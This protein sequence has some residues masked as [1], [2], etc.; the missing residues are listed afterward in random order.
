M[1]RAAAVGESSPGVGPASGDAC[2][3]HFWWE[4]SWYGRFRDLQVLVDGVARARVGCGQ[5]VMVPVA[6]GEHAVAVKMDW[7]RTAPLFIECLPSTTAQFLC[8]PR[9][10]PVA[11][12]ATFLAP[13][14]VFT[15]RRMPAD[16]SA[17]SAGALTS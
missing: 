4:S 6:P 8:Q 12:V 9:S 15:V 3:L 11:L 7:C 2:L 16:S 14:E 5:S 13:A 10:F 17:N 1:S